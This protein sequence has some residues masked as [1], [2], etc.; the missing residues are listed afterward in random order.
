I[1]TLSGGTVAFQ[2]RLASS[3][4]PVWEKV[5][6]PAKG[7]VLEYSVD[8]GASWT[9]MLG[10]TTAD[11]YNWT[12]VATG[13]PLA[14]RTASTQFRWRQLTHSGAAFDHWALDDVLISATA[15]PA[16]ITNQ[17]VSTTAFVGSTAAFSVGAAGAPPLAYQWWFNGMPLA[18][19]NNSSLL[20][21]NVAPG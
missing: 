11:F 8:G 6:L 19:Q 9:T 3:N 13:I 1:D 7:V 15:L 5:D 18:L 20:L 4:S 17:P 2:L 10:C 16:V 21:S 12:Q 14:A